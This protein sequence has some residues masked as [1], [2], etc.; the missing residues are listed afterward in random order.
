VPDITLPNVFVADTATSAADVAANLYNP[1]A[2]PNSFEVVNGQLDNVN[3]EAGWDIGWEHVRSNSMARGR[4][5]GATVNLDYFP[6]T[7]P[8][9][10]TDNG[11]YVPLPGL[12]I[13]W[14]QP[15]ISAMT[16]LMWQV[17]ITNDFSGGDPPEYLQR[18]RLRVDGDIGADKVDQRRHI[19]LNRQ[20]ILPANDRRPYRDRV[21]S[22]HW[23]KAQMA[24]GHHTAGV[25]M[26][27]TGEA[28]Q[29]PFATS[30]V[31]VS[32][33]VRVRNMKVFWI[34]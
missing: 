17:T 34:A 2:V 23:S 6:V 32:A 29:F 3:R 27:V 19:P 21:L 4:M 15:V 9:A 8:H 22:M 30:E 7:F 14:Y 31:P 12:C 25:E 11:A 5:V 24:A 26:W 1:A 20:G 16:F 28:A 18:L 33:R 13:E 10:E